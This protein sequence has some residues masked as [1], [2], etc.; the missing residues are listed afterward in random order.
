MFP[1]ILNIPKLTTPRNPNP[2]N[3]IVSILHHS[4]PFGKMECKSPTV[5]TSWV[6]TSFVR[7]PLCTC[8]LVGQS[9]PILWDPMDCMGYRLPGSSVHGDSA[10]KNTGVGCRFLLQGIFPTQILNPGLL[11]CRQILLSHQESPLCVYKIILKCVFL[12][13]C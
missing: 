9:C 13:S 8:V 1:R 7:R 10:G 12:F 5:T 4:L 3:F 2:L 11:H 6:F